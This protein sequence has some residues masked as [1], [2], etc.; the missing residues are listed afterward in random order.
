M[1]MV[2]LSFLAAFDM[3]LNSVLCTCWSS[4]KTRQNDSSAHAYIV[5]NNELLNFTAVFLL[6][7]LGISNLSSFW[8]VL[9]R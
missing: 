6:M 2:V 8:G 7:S 4:F 9:R 3:K 1:V 5:P